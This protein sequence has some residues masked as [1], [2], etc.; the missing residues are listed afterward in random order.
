MSM[1]PLFDYAVNK[2]AESR[3]ILTPDREKYLKRA[4]AYLSAWPEDQAKRLMDKHVRRV[5][6]LVA[7]RHSMDGLEVIGY[8]G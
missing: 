1:I 2:L 5:V 7:T 8:K 4:A 6:V 3:I